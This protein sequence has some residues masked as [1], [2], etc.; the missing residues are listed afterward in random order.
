MFRLLSVEERYRHWRCVS[1]RV[2]VEWSGGR[3]EMR[4][5]MI[6]Y[7]SGVTILD[8][9]NGKGGIYI[10]FCIDVKVGTE[11]VYRMQWFVLIIH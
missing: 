9:I 8:M 6:R 2:C 5:S 4:N 11:E 7:R 3:D 1:E 10:R